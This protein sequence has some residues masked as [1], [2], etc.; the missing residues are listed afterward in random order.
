M[1]LS[2]SFVS[3][4]FFLC[5]HAAVASP[6]RPNVIVILTDDLGRGDLGCYGAKDIRTPQLDR[7]AA[8]GTRFTDFSV[9]SALCTPSRAGLM[10]GRYPGRAGLAAGVLRPD[11]TNGL[12]KEEITLADLFKSTGYATACIG[13][14]HLGYQ[15]GMRPLDQGFDSY[16]GVLHNLDRFEACFYEKEG[17]V[18][19]LRDDKVVERPAEP[20]RLTALYTHEALEFI[21]RHRDQPFFLYLAHNMPHLPFDASPRFKGKS[22]RGLYGDVVEELDDSTGQILNKLRELGLAEKTMVFFTSDNGPESGT[23]GSSGDLRGGKHTVFEGGIRM[24]AIAW[25]PGRIPAARVSDEFI[26]SL[27]LFPTF[28]VLSGADVPGN[29][30]LDGFD[31]V[32]VL[33]GTAGARSPRTMLYSFYGIN[34]KRLE[35]MREGYWKLLP[36]PPVQLYKLARDPGESTNLAEEHPDLVSR[37]SELARRFRAETRIPETGAAPEMS[38]LT[39]KRSE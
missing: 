37:L 28:A 24:P 17:G 26:C 20:S 5:C 33:L 18:P 10:T 21:E 27:D 29:V 31:I 38:P 1:P 12:A 14:W 8:E 2:R 19:V 34:N 16:F 11:A 13:K 35:S 15:P 30:T 32:P 9:V 39:S 23:P 7:M 4:I 6:P 3:A 22:A 36:G 25:W